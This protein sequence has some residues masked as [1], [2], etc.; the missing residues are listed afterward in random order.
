MIRGIGFCCRHLR[1]GSGDLRRHHDRRCRG[2]KRSRP[3]GLQ[4][5]A[6]ASALQSD[7]ASAPFVPREMRFV[8]FAIR[9]LQ[10]SG[11]SS[12]RA[13]RLFRCIMAQ[14]SASTARFASSVVIIALSTNDPMWS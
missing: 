1:R 12:K 6:L 7:I 5:Q 9:I 13:C 4:V 11:R 3:K 14:C 10:G 2:E 8:T